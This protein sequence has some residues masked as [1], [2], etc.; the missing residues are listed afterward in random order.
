MKANA[1][2]LQRTLKVQDMM[3]LSCLIVKEACI[4]LLHLLLIVKLMRLEVGDALRSRYAD[5][6]LLFKK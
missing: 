5:A 3:L 1:E 4:V 6:W 2:G